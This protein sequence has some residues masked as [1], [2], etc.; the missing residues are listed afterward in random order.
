MILQI[1]RR[2]EEEMKKRI[3]GLLLLALGVTTV[4]S[5]G[6]GSGDVDDR[7]LILSS[8]ELDKVFNPFYSSS[9]PDSRGRC[10]ARPPASPDRSC[11]WSHTAKWRPD[12]CRT[13]GWRGFR[14]LY[15]A[16]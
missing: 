14:P 6:T 9:A 5:C 11:R 15:P 7:A 3:L 8:Q 16:N 2:G 13:G 1:I 12:G 10:S 4:A